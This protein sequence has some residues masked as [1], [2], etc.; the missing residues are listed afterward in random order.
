M[1]T[2]IWSL[3][4]QELIVLILMLLIT[5]VFFYYVSKYLC[6]IGY[7]NL[8]NSQENFTNKSCIHSN[9]Q[10][11]AETPLPFTNKNIYKRD[12]KQLP[13]CK[14]WSNKKQPELKCFINKHLHR[15]C[16]W[17]C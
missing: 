17:S 1:E 4:L 14:S 2:S 16:Y 9:I 10:I 8:I 6:K 13:W 12:D 15:K 11:L 7:E 3:T 5:Y